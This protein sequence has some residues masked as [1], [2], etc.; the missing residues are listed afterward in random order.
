[1]ILFKRYQLTIPRADRFMTD[2]LA[3]TD[4]YGAGDS[5]ELAAL[6]RGVLARD[7]GQ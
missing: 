3:L 6:R 5:D 4:A 1:M 2:L 7:G